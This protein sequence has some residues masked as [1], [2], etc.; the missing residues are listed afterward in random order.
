MPYIS[1]KDQA[2]FSELTAEIDS[3]DI[4]TAGELNFLV[5]K[6]MV[7]YLEV[8]G[9]RYQHMN[10]IVGAVE[11]AKAEFQRRVVGPYEKQKAFET[12]QIGCDPYVN[13][14]L[15]LQL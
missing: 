15:E 13:S 10:D 8:N 3:A 1:E 11:G 7:R 14:Q 2:S 6:L 12:E 9:V 4:Q 5:T